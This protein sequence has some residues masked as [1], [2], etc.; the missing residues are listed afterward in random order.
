[1]SGV[2]RHIYLADDGSLHATWMLHYALRMARHLERVAVE[3]LHVHELDASTLASRRAHHAAL[4]SRHQVELDFTLLDPDPNVAR[5]LSAHV[6]ASPAHL[7]VAG[8]RA[9]THGHGLAWGTVGHA[10]LGLHDRAVLAM[11][12]VSPGNLGLPGTAAMG[13]S[14][15]EGLESR[16]LPVLELLAPDLDE[17]VLLR[18]IEVLRRRARVLGPDDVDALLAEGRTWLMDFSARVEARLS[19]EAPR[20]DTR[21][22]VS[23][24]WPAQ[25]VMEANRVHAQLLLLG[26]SDHML[27]DKFHFTNPLETILRNAACDVAVFRAARR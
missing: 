1:M 27:D 6:P 7:V 12:I 17:L 5:A 3:V 10:L 21:V 18:V 15:S 25:L 23:H 13:V 8:F 11:R 9:H 20:V 4:A 24:D 2:V 26:A 19:A 22:S 16:L 14:E